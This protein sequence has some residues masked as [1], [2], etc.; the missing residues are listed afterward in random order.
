MAVQILFIGFFKKLW[1]LID[2]L[3]TILFLK[4]NTV[5]TNNFFD[6][7]FPW[8]RE[9]T[10]WIPLYFFLILF[11]IINYKRKAFAWI[12]FFVVTI[13][14]SDQI[15]SGI[16]KDW[17][18]RARPCN[19]LFLQFHMRLLLNRCPSSGSF[20]SSHATNHFAAAMFLWITLKPAFKNW[21]YLFFFWA[22]TI[23]YGQ[24]YVGVHY[25]LDVLGGCM[26]GLL[27]GWASATFFNK[28][29]GFPSHQIVAAEL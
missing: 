24:V 5:Y 26:L 25:P 22:A 17:I 11:T 16:L 8:W 14:L 12:A 27:I 6:S 23:S 21:G 29:L 9:A 10:T 28:K 7:F 15:S 4:I 19:D 1:Y 2:N 20:T 3:D 13:I 18:G